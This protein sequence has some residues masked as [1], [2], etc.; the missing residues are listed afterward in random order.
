MTNDSF[1][2]TRGH[3][4]S[5][6]VLHVPHS[7]REIPSQVRS[8][9][10][11][12][13]LAL[14]QELDAMTDSGTDELA[15]IAAGMSSIKPWIFRNKLSRLV[16]DPERFPD[17]RE[18]MNSIGMGAVYVKTSSG[19]ELRKVD[20]ERDRHLL[21]TYFHPYAASFDA[22]IQ[23]LFREHGRVTIIDVHSYRKQEHVNSLNK[24]QRRPAVCLGV[25]QFHTPDWLLDLATTS[26]GNLGEIVINEPYAGTYVP[27]SLYG[28]EPKVTSVMMENREDTILGNKMKSAATA[29]SALIEQIHVS[30][31]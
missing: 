1:E 9:L 5:A 18:L 6:V 8:D 4:D 31:K 12:D 13:D 29:L 2:I 21:D 30:E 22:L 17:D 3:S 24:G 27:L 26:F 23:E 25:D 15:K 10:L 28:K 20:D 14:E 7:S 16:I 19:E 11:I